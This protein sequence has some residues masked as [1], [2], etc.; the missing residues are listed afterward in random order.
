MKAYEVIRFLEEIY[1]LKYQRN[2]D[3]SGIQI[4]SAQIDVRKI[5]VAYEKT[6][7]VISECVTNRCDML[8]THRPLLMPRRYGYPPQTW[9]A[10][11]KELMK[12]SNMI[13][14]SIH[15]NL[16]LGTNSTA[17]H[18]SR[19]LG[20]TPVKEKA[21]Y[22]VCKTGPIAFRD[23]VSQV[24][25]ALKPEYIVSV[26]SDTS[27]IERIGLVA[28]TAM[29]IEDIEF[30]KLASVNCYLSG[31]PDDFGIRYARDLGIMTINVDDYS[32][33]RPAILSIYNLLAQT[34]GEIDVQFVDCRYR[35]EDR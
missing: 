20:L 27:T 30:F 16:D 4:G 32:L 14:Y 12:N 31:D 7:D 3:N 21:P 33:E 5:A 17:Q 2:D 22:L 24:R 25:N 1:P 15:E 10:I 13:I 34:F 26:G 11:F 8:I 29:G 35:R 9:W 19:S 23:F 6:L 28:G 18:L